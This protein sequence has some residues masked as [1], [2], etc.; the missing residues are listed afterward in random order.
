M[1]GLFM[2]GSLKNICESDVILCNSLID[3]YANV[4]A[5]RRLGEF[6]TRCHPDM[7]SLRPP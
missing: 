4:G 1:I 3:M 7:L 6:S 5:L 2:N